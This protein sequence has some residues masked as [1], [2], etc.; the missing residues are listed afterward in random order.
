MKEQLQQERLKVSSAFP[1]LLFF[2]VL[3]KI[4]V[5]LVMACLARE[6]ISFQVFQVLIAAAFL[7]TSGIQFCWAGK[8]GS[9]I[10]TAVF[11]QCHFPQV[12]LGKHGIF[13]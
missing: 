13:A 7:S 12:E 8:H 11:V 4:I 10:L 6:S 9:F 5:T 3:P 1:I 2:I